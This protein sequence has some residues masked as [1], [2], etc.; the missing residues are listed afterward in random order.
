MPLLFLPSAGTAWTGGERLPAA[1]RSAP[2]SGYTAIVSPDAGGYGDEQPR[3][4]LAEPE[5]VKVETGDRVRFERR[6]RDV[7]WTGAGFEAGTAIDRIPT[8]ELRARLQKAYGD[9]TQKLKHLMG[10]SGFRPGH[11]IQFEY[12][13]IIDGDIPMMV[14][15]ID[16]PFGRGLVFAGASRYVDL[17]PE[18]KRTLTRTLLNVPELGEYEDHYYELNEQQWYRA[19][20]RDGSFFNEKVAR[21]AELK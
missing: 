12:W 16:G 11:Y 14:L 15:D 10:E 2:E 21:P 8:R 20:Y 19:G 13:F 18:V 4:L 17:M 6:F 5:I 9:P 3:D 1:H 7:Q